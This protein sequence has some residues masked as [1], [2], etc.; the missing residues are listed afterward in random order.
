MCREMFDRRYKRSGRGV[1]HSPPFSVEINPL[2]L[3]M[4]I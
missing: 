2:A 1:D 3:E 4:D